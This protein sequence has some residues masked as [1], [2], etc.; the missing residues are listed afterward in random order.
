[1]RLVVDK[2]N[3]SLNKSISKLATKAV[4]KY[5]VCN[6]NDLCERIFET[7]RTRVG[8]EL[9]ASLLSKS[10]SYVG[11]GEGWFWLK[12][13]P[14]NHLCTIIRKMLAV[15]PRLHVSEIRAG[16]VSDPRGMGFAPP[17]PVVLAFCK[18]ALGCV[19]EEEEFVRALAADHPTDVLSESELII[20]GVLEERGPLLHRVEFERLCVERDMNPITFSMYLARSPIVARYAPSIYGLIGAVFSPSELEQLSTR[21]DTERFSDHGWTRKAQPWVALEVTSSVL[22][23]GITHIPAGINEIVIGRYVLKTEGGDEVGRLVVSERAAGGLTSLFRRCGSEIGDVLV[24]TFDINE[25]EVIAR[26][27]EKRTVLPEVVWSVEEMDRQEDA[28]ASTTS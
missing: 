28:S 20:F 22:T 5:G 24:L 19:I 18:S 3:V 10:A 14:R 17:K 13:V 6:V 26:I 1:M 15:A 11:L 16:L 2:Y 7:T 23:T 9:V 12:D 27:G 21:R 4:S 25:H 8:D